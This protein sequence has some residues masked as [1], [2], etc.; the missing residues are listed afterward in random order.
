MHAVASHTAA[1][2]PVARPGVRYE[3]ELELVDTGDHITVAVTA[4]SAG[5]A[6]NAAIA[7]VRNTTSYRGPIVRRG[8]REV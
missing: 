4:F 3:V 6:A 8:H 2:V 7:H 5:R 1:Y